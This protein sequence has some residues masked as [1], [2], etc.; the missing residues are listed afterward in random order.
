VR[1]PTDGKLQAAKYLKPVSKR[2][3][4]PTIAAFLERARKEVG[5]ARGYVAADL[6][7]Y[8]A[9]NENDTDIGQRIEELAPHLDYICPMVYPSGYHV[10]IP[11]F[12]NPVQNSYAVVARERAADPQTRAHHAGPRPPLAA[13]LQGLRVRPA[14]LRRIGDPRPDPRATRGAAAAGC[15]GTR[16]TTTRA[17]RCGPRSRWRRDEAGTRRRPAP[18]RC[19]DVR[20][21]RLGGSALANELGRLM[22]L[23]YHNGRLSGGPV[24]AHAENFR[25][26]L[27]ALYARGYRL[28]SLNA[29]LDGRIMARPGRRR[30]C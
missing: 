14:D 9:F 16:V 24:D 17:G 10:G 1:F 4:L 27:E 21:L 30:S 12:R 20:R 3:A 13:G 25:Q 23:E 15:S 5:A 22:I 26:D 18:G 28:H 6:F 19:A 8:T 29:L 2:R 7:G 11:G